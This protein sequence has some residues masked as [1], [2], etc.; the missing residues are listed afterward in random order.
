MP[1]V[2]LSA[3]VSPP[4]FANWVIASHSPLCHIGSL[5]TA[6]RHDE[7]DAP[8]RNRCLGPQ[9]CG[10]SLY[11]HAIRR[12]YVVTADNNS[13]RTWSPVTSTASAARSTMELDDAD[14][15]MPVG[16]RS[17]RP[18]RAASLVLNDKGRDGESDL[19]TSTRLIT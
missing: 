14:G 1:D 16:R 13:L 9:L 7:G 19:R 11:R 2:S 4:M 12:S 3:A 18:H 10:P 6:G 5:A 15:P 17:C 8:N